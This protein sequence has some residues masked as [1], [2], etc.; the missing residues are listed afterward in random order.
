M[1]CRPHPDPNPNPIPNLNRNPESFELISSSRKSSNSK[2]DSKLD[3][4]IFVASVSNYCRTIPA[5]FNLVN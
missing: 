4:M 1:K 5:T 2:L 3:S